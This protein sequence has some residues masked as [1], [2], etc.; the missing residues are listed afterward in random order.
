MS[1]FKLITNTSEGVLQASLAAAKTL[2]GVPIGPL[3]EGETIS[4]GAR[5][6]AEA[7]RKIGRSK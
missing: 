5:K 1:L 7:L 6:T 3:D 2:A 4:Q